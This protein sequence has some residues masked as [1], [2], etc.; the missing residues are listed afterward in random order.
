MRAERNRCADLLRV[1]AIGAVVLGHWLLIDVTFRDGRLSGLDALDYVGWARWVTLLLQVMPVFFL[2]GGFANAVSWQARREQG[3]DWRSWVQGRAARLLWPTVMYVAVCAFAVVTARIAG[4]DSAVLARAGWLVAL[5]LWFLPVYLLLIALTPLLHAAHRRWGLAVPAVMALGAAG[6]DALVLGA[7]LPLVGFMNYLLVWG[8]MHQWGFAWQ[9]GTLTTPRWRCRALAA[10]G[11]VLLA[12]LLG[13]GPFPVDMIGAGTRVGNTSPP[14]IA[15]LAFA[16]AQ[17]GLL[18]MAEPAL[19]RL[20]A[21]PGL[22]RRIS[23]FNAAVMTVYLWHMVPV[24]LVAL[25]LYPT[26]LAPQPA[27][28]TAAWLALRLPWVALL[29][30]VMIPLVLVLLRAQRPLLR[31]PAGV[32]PTGWWSAPLLVCG[33]AFCLPALAVLAIGGFAPGGQL[34]VLP[35]TLCAV[36]LV[37]VVCSGRPRQVPRRTKALGTPSSPPPGRGRPHPGRQTTPPHLPARDFAGRAPVKNRA[38]ADFEETPQLAVV[39]TETAPTNGRDQHFP[40]RPQA[41]Q[42]P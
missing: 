20:L 35:L 31:L 13:W 7:R 17:T 28:G 42:V 14:S 18:L 29:S 3:E 40:G 2:V 30:A 41:G 23:R 38:W 39:S 9:D 5:H 26:G 22:W 8:S 27:I 21:R 32:G 11:V 24:I 25:A 15:L 6:V 37:A 19:L 1:C 36:G 12:A 34:A 4:A 33:L 10:G 16:A